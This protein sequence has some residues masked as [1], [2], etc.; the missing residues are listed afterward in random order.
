MGGGE[1]LT[2]KTA[3]LSR[4]TPRGLSSVG[5]S[6]SSGL[7]AVLET[8]ALMHA[9]GQAEAAKEVL[10]QAIATEPE[11]AKVALVWLALLDIYQQTDDKESFDRWGMEY[12]VR[13]EQSP[14]VWASR[15]LPKE[16]KPLLKEESYSVVA[17]SGEIALSNIELLE[18]LIKARKEASNNMCR[19]NL[20]NAKLV[21]EG[22]AKKLAKELATVRER[23]E[24][25]SLEPWPKTLIAM[26]TKKARENKEKEGQGYWMLLLEL[27]QWHRDEKAFDHYAVE[28]AVRFEVSPPI[29]APAKALVKTLPEKDEEVIVSSANI[30]IPSAPNVWV[31]SGVLQG[32]RS[33]QLDAFKD[34]VNLHD[35]IVVDMHDVLRVDF[36]FGGALANQVARAEASKKKI[37]FIRS[38]P[39]VLSLL[40][41]VGFPPRVFSRKR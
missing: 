5:G 35:T 20:S 33:P 25:T 37:R 40:L 18:P 17:L 27:L 21:D 14:P 10:E 9:S 38:S 32:S 6:M 13:F 31:W 26:L 24:N 4:V 19:L 2:A 30:P 23:F 29:W 7:N 3:E 28:Y 16:N 36:A 12:A 8:A 1:T 34:F 41:L 11:T 22:G 15:C 39:M